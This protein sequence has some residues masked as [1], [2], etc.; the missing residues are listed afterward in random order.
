[1]DYD[2]IIFFISFGWFI[3]VTVIFLMY[4]RIRQISEEMK[5]IKNTVQLSTDEITGLE[6]DVGTV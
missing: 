6:R 5:V 1:M 3:S 2:N 4:V